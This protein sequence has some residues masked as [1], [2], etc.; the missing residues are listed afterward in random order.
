ME[1]VDGGQGVIEG[2]VGVTV[3]EPVALAQGAAVACTRKKARFTSSTRRFRTTPQ[4]E[5]TVERQATARRPRNR[6]TEATADE[7]ATEAALLAE[8]SLQS[9]V[10]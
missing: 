2:T 7:A 8:P 6:G 4:T 10:K 3:V 9:A 1:Q 5:V